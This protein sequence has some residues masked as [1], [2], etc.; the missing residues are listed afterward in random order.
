MS[1]L[2]LDYFFRPFFRQGGVMKPLSVWDWDDEVPGEFEIA[3]LSMLL[4]VFNA[5]VSRLTEE[6]E[7]EVGKAEALVISTE[8]E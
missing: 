4:R 5:L 6:V 2:D 1:L 8:E 7:W 3:V